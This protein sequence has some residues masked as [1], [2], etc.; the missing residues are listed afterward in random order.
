MSTIAHLA[1]I[2]LN[3]PS[4][5]SEENPDDIVDW[6]GGDGARLQI[7]DCAGTLNQKWRRA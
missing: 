6:N 3:M 5:S 2:S 4:L 1:I 7:W